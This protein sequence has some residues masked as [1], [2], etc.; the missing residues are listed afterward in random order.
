MENQRFPVACVDNHEPL[1]Q[2]PCRELAEQPE[3]RRGLAEEM[4]PAEVRAE[5]NVA[6]FI[7][8]FAMNIHI[9]LDLCDPGIDVRGALVTVALAEARGGALFCCFFCGS[10]LTG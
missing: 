4:V 8:R 7:E 6:E 5:S 1:G 9:L 3:I 10:A 2:V